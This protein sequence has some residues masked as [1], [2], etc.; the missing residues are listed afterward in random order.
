MA[1]IAGFADSAV[2]AREAQL[3]AGVTPQISSVASQKA[4]PASEKDWIDHVNSL[5]LGSPERAK[6]YDSYYEWLTQKK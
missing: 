5:P 2:K 4:V 3:L 6:A 1:D